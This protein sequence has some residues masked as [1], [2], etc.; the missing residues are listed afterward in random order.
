MKKIILALTLLCFSLGFSQITNTVVKKEHFEASGFPFLG[1]HVL[2]VEKIATPKEKNYYVFS[3]NER[4]SLQDELYIQQFK[5]VNNEWKVVA[6]DI[7]AEAGI[8]TSVWNAR[9]AFF[10]ADKDGQAD[11]LFVYS[12]HPKE[13]MDEQLSVVLL[14]IY[15][16]KFYRMESSA[17]NNYEPMFDT[18]DFNPEDLPA[19][20]F[21]EFKDYWNN[22]DKN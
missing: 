1:T 13:N 9:K 7:V 21:K 3:K 18:S 14:L 4:G 12:K 11:V 6:E 5:K 16:N 17:Q 22:L 10:D 8:I 19:T 20:V 2:Q 15:K